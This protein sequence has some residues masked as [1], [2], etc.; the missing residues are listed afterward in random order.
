MTT[1][2]INKKG[3]TKLKDLVKHNDG[4]YFRFIRCA[5]KPQGL[6]EG[7]G[8]E[9]FAFVWCYGED[10]GIFSNSSFASVEDPSSTYA[11]ATFIHDDVELL[12]LIDV[13]FETEEG[14]R[15]ADH[16]EADIG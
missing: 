2:R 7:R 1:V 13:T 15:K 4:F 3:E 16:L 5:C 14:S 11:A 6:P 12:K 10:R 9:S 8:I